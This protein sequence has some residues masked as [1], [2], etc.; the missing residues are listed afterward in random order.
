M[1]NRQ[2]GKRRIL[3]PVR[4]RQSLTPTD[5]I[6]TDRIEPRASDACF[7]VSRRSINS[8]A[9]ADHPATHEVVQNLVCHTDR[10]I[11]LAPRKIRKSVGRIDIQLNSGI[12]PGK[13]DQLT[14]KK[15]AQHGWWYAQ[16]HHP[17][18]AFIAPA[19]APLHR[20]Q[21]C[22]DAFSGSKEIFTRL[23]QHQTIWRSIEES[24]SQRPFEQFQAACHGC[25]IDT[26]CPRGA[27]KRSGTFYGKKKAKVVPIHG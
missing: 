7:E 13:G 17:T 11:R 20:R 16:P 25:M 1:P 3:R 9:I 5:P 21:L 23:R 19:D 18:R 10:D 8:L 4:I 2:I 15:R 24:R 14:R 12:K 22:F 6:V 27:T 26:N